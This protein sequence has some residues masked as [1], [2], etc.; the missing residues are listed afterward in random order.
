[1]AQLLELHASSTGAIP[2]HSESRT[3]IDCLPTEILEI[4]ITFAVEGRQIQVCH[5]HD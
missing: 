5:R 4:I 1:M 3:M 2:E